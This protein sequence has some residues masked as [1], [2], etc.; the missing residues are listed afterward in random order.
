MAVSASEAR[1]RLRMVCRDHNPEQVAEL[2]AF[3]SLN[4]ADSTATLRDVFMDPTAIR[5]LL[6]NG[7][8]VS[9]IHI[10]DVP[11]NEQTGEILR[12][13][14]EYGYN[15][16]TEGHRILAPRSWGKHQSHRPSTTA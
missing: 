11:E 3:Q 4:A 16:A 9:A 1:R 8:D 6:E 7:A 2:L 15:F 14:D 10:R 12:L 5:I 13:L